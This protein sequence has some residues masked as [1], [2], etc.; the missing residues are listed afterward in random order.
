LLGIDDAAV[1]QLLTMLKTD[2]ATAGV[3]VHTWVARREQTDVEDIIADVNQDASCH[4]IA[5]QMN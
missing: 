3:P 5:I 4:S 2:S 1:C